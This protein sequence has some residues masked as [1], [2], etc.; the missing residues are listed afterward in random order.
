MISETA[1]L[2]ISLARLYSVFVKMF[3]LISSLVLSEVSSDLL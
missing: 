2:Y 1:I 3:E